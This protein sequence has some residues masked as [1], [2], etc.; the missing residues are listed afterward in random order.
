MP[1]VYH[2]ITDKNVGGGGRVLTSLVS[3]AKR[4][5]LSYRV[6]LPQ[7]SALIPILK[8]KK[9]SYDAL[10]GVEDTSF[11]FSSF[12]SFYRYLRKN[13]CDALI[14]HASLSARIAGRLCGIPLLLAVKHC[15]VG[16][17]HGGLLYRALTDHTV[18]VSQNASDALLR[19]GVKES[20]ITVIEN[21]FARAT[22][23]TKEEKARA[24]AQFGI[25]EGEIAVGLSGRLAPVKG[26]ET[27]L[28]ALKKALP[29]LP[30]LSLW[31]LGEGEERGRLSSLCAALGVSERVR[32]LGFAEDTR[33]FYRAIDA[34]ISCSL[35][36]ETASLSLA[37]GMSYGC[38]TLASDIE[39]NRARV[40]DGGLFF[41]P[42]DAEALASLFLRL[43]DPRFRQEMSRAARLRASTLPDEEES[44]SRFEALLL[45]LLKKRLHF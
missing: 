22:P 14:S 42:G 17:R 25:K 32:F 33:P 38:V 34:H 40:G 29:C 27:A 20:E 4:E 28:C 8:H 23:P 44:A 45:A 43:A 15:A 19:L 2:I 36:S 11:S 6:L 10:N 24:R 7:N 35:D 16:A 26:H 30:S 1:L 13:P 3:H 39:G 21:G 9:I 12:L 5:C 18:A 41:P 37:E 31:F